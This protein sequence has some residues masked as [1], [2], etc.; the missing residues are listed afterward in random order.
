[1]QIREATED[2]WPAI[3]PIFRA[4]VDAGETYAY[5][6]GL[7]MEAA[8]PL[9][10]EP[11]PGRTFVAVDGDRVLGSAK[12]GPNRP[13]RGSHVATASF[14]VDPAAQGRGAGRALGEHVVAAARADGY[15]AMQFNAVVETNTAAVALWRSL[16][17]RVVGTVP[18]AFEHPE[19][20]F[21]GLHVMHLDLRAG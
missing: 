8:R 19:H 5:P 7:S 10:M 16:G 13:G 21:V 12:T 4:V 9:W 6:A 14:M 3:H 2:D 11:S 20:G 1:M 17:F 18:E 15:R